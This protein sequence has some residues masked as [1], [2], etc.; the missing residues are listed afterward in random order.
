MRCRFDGCPYAAAYVCEMDRG[1]VCF[2]DERV[3]ALCAQHARKSEPLGRW[4]ARPIRRGRHL[5]LRAVGCALFYALLPSRAYEPK[6][7]Y[8]ESY[9]RHAWRNVVLAW[10]WATGSETQGDYEF[11]LAANW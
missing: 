5:R 2:P 3:Q 6:R 7:H 9:V 1:C 10:R 8:S 4:S 11:E